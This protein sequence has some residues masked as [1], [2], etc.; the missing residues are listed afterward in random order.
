MIGSAGEDGET[1]V[2][3]AAAD[4]SF[5]TSAVM[6]P[7]YD[8]GLQ[9]RQGRRPAL[10]RRRGVA[11]CVDGIDAGRSILLVGPTIRDGEGP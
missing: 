2:A 11:T 8:G 5:G 7:V 10:N 3:S 6:T 1:G 9:P 4:A